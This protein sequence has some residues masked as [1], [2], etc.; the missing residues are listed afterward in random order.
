[1]VQQI[2]MISRGA[3]TLSSGATSQNDYFAERGEPGV[4]Q[5][6]IEHRPA[7]G[8]PAP[9]KH[10]VVDELIPAGRWTERGSKRHRGQQHS[11]S[12][13]QWRSSPTIERERDIRESKSA[14]PLPCLWN[15][16]CNTSD[17]EPQ[18]P[19]AAQQSKL[20]HNDAQPADEI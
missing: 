19:A 1:M 17:Q 10:M 14:P 11:A 5:I 3:M 7:I 9:R 6:G 16:E 2:Q 8:Q 12:H 20:P 18:G 13:M 4:C 15:A